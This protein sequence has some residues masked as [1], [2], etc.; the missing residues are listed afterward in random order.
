MQYFNREADGTLL[1]STAGSYKRYHTLGW[2]CF[3]CI[4]I[5]WSSVK[6]P[7]TVIKVEKHRVCLLETWCVFSVLF[8]MTSLS[9]YLCIKASGKIMNSLAP[10]QGKSP[11]YLLRV[12]FFHSQFCF[13]F[14]QLRAT[15]WQKLRI[16]GKELLQLFNFI[17]TINHYCKY[18]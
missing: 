6:F 2:L 9:G 3:V 16:V 10:A 11:T 5:R 8:R 4:N 14:S 18:Y 7:G 15:K 13:L 12:I 17:K 1:I